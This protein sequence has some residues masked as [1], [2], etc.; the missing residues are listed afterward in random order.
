MVI[1]PQKYKMNIC[2]ESFQFCYW[3]VGDP[4]LRLPGHLLGQ[5]LAGGSGK[6]AAGRHRRGRV[7]AG[8]LEAGLPPRAQQRSKEEDGLS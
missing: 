6:V 4:S 5:P 7:G 2:M 1:P 8:R 3:P